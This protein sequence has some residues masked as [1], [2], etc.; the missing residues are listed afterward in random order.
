MNEGECGERARSEKQDCIAYPMEEFKCCSESLCEVSY[1]LGLDG[2]KCLL[3]LTDVLKVG[4]GKNKML[5]LFKKMKD[6]AMGMTLL[7]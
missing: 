4:L 6:Q 2:L 5:R 7:L 3:K 1:F